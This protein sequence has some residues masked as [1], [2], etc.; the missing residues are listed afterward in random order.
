MGETLG[1]PDSAQREALASAH[2]NAAMSQSL[3]VYISDLEQPLLVATR[4]DDYLD[5]KQ[6]MLV[7]ELCNNCTYYLLKQRILYPKGAKLVKKQFN[8]IISNFSRDRVRSR[9][10]AM[11]T[12]FN[13]AHRD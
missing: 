2:P 10:A 6:I 9:A 12:V 4:Y 8:S 13:D 5:K 7:C 1:T 3:A 11:S